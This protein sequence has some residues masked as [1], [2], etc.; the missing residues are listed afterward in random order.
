MKVKIKKQGA[1]SGGRR[2]FYFFAIIFT[3]LMLSLLM[4]F[5]QSFSAGSKD[6]VLDIIQQN[7]L[8]SLAVFGCVACILLLYVLDTRA[9][10][11]APDKRRNF[12]IPAL[13]LIVVFVAQILLFDKR[14]IAFSPVLLCVLLT[15]VLVGT[16][17]GLFINAV[18]AALS[19]LSLALVG[20][21]SGTDVATLNLQSVL[22][23][24]ITGAIMTILLTKVHSR[25]GIVCAGSLISIFSY[26]VA[27]VLTYAITQSIEQSQ[28]IA[29]VCALANVAS[30]VVFM[31]LLPLFESAFKVCTDFKLNEYCSFSKPLLQ[32]LATE[33]PGTFSHCMVV[34]SLAESCAM[35]IGEN[36]LLA[37]TAAYYHD[38]GKLKNAMF[39]VEN[40]KGY[41]PHDELIPSV[42]AKKILSHT[43]YG[44]ELLKQYGYPDE[45]CDVALQHHGT[46]VAKFFYNKAML[47]TEGNVDKTEYSYSG[48][49]PL[50]KIAAIVM[51]SDAAEAA[52]RA[53]KEQSIT[54]VVNA[55]IKERLEEGQFD[56][57]PIT[58]KE[59]DTIAETL[60]KVLSYIHHKRISYKEN[61]V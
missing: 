25:V 53:M 11:P 21:Y 12:I 42:S 39:F 61:L 58:L 47:I 19:V 40:Q 43:Q 16:R 54:D 34:S 13:G 10:N 33:A 9:N 18:C 50:S 4:I 37:R 44:Y 1:L 46:T 3:A 27:F 35:A 60:S 59:L 28:S 17:A 6:N 56:D 24:F 14:D 22:V 36:V 32:R 8:Q 45:I 48:P 55:I 23:Y 2:A 29:F 51:I 41:N 20:V 49:K 57:C 7:P 31:F 52:V 38:V 5:N 26:A 15:A 30:V